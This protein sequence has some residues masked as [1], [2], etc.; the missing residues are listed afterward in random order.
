LNIQEGQDTGERNNE[1]IQ[2]K[3]RIDSGTQ[4]RGVVIDRQLMHLPGF[5]R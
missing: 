2:H 1:Q 5:V 4:Q 3:A